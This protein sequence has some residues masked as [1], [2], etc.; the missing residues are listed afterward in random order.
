MLASPV[1]VP[2]AAIAAPVGLGIAAGAAAFAATASVIATICRISY[3]FDK[4]VKGHKK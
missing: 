4:D 1:F 3:F 2:F